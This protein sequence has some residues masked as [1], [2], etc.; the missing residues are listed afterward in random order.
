MTDAAEE[1]PAARPAIEVTS[2][3]L[4]NYALAHNRVPMVQHVTITNPTDVE[5][6]CALTVELSDSEG[7]LAVPWERSLTLRAGEQRTLDDINLRADPA[8]LLQVEEERPGTLRATVRHGSDPFAEAAKPVRVLAA[9][10]WLATGTSL[11]YEILPAFVMPNHPVVS[12]HLV[13][14]ADILGRQTGTS[15]LNGYQ[16]GPERVDAI[17]AAV[18][19]AVQCLHVRYAEPPASWGDGQKVRNPAQVLDERLG[20]CLDTVVGMA[21]ML[22]QAGIHPLLWVAEGHAFLGWWREEETSLAQIVAADTRRLLNLV[23]TGEIGLV[24]TTLVTDSDQPVG[25]AEARSA[26]ERRWTEED[27]GALLA[28]VDVN[29]ARRSG[30]TPLPARVRDA[31]GQVQITTYVPAEHS[32]PTLVVNGRAPETPHATEIAPSRVQNW[33]NALLDLSLRNRLINLP[34]DKASFNV[35]L[36]S[37]SLGTL[38]DLISADVSLHLFPADDVDDIHR[39]RGGLSAR[40]LPPEQLHESLVER[41]RVFTSLTQQTYQSRLR[42]LAHKARTIEEDT[43]ANNLYLTYGSLIWD[44]DGRE[45]RSPLILVPITLRAPARGYAYRLQMDPAGGSTPNFCL[46]EKLRQVHGL[47]IAALAE[48]EFDQSGIDLDGILQAVRIA[49]AQAGISARVE[50]SADV[51]ILQF[52]KFRL[53]RDLDQNWQ[54]FARNPLVK[55]LLET[56]TQPFTAAVADEPATDLDSLAANLPISAD[57]S[58]LR[59][60]ARATSGAT[61]VLEGPPGTGKSQTITNLLAHAMAEGRKV[62]FV[63]EKRAALDVVRRRLDAVGMGTFA[64]D[65]HDKSSK[66]LAVRAQIRKALDSTFAVDRHGLAAATEDMSAAARVLGRYAGR[67]HEENGAGLSLYSAHERLLAYGDGPKLAVPTALVGGDPDSVERVRSALRGLPDVADAIRPRPFH[68]WG[69]VDQALDDSTLNITRAAVERADHAVA[70]LPARAD[71]AP[72]VAAARNPKDLRT[73]AEVF[74]HRTIPLDALDATRQ[75]WW[76]DQARQTADEIRMFVTAAHPGLDVVTPNALDMPLPDILARARAAASS[77]FFGRKKRIATV[78]AELNLVLRPGAS[79]APKQL[80]ALLEALVQVQGA[81][82]HVASRVMSVNGVV[83]PPGWNPLTQGGSQIVEAQLSWLEWAGGALDA[84]AP[85][86]SFVGLVRAA[87]RSGMTVTAEEVGRLREAADASENLER[88]PGVGT[89]AL[90]RWAGGKGLVVAIASTAASRGSATEAARALK[91][92]STFVDQLEPL[93]NAGMHDARERLSRGGLD[94]DLAA[95]AFARGIATASIAERREATGLVDF[96]PATHT[97]SIERFLHSSAALRDLMRAELPNRVVTA[98]PFSPS[99]GLG[100]VGALQRELGRQRGGM[101]V[102]RLLATFGDLIIS[103]MP[104]VL[105]SPESVARFLPAASNLFDLVV[106]DEASQ[107]RVADAVGSMGRGRSVIV[108]GD[109]RQMPPTSFAESSTTADDDFEDEDIITVEDEESILSECVQA[110]VPRDWLS[111]HY[112]SQDETLIAFSNQHYY[113]SRLSSFPSPALGRTDPR[114]G[115]RG[116]NFVRVDGS[117]Q[118]SGRGKLLRTNQVEANA[119]VDDI[120]ARFAA[121]PDRNPSVGVVTFNVQQRALI[122]TMLR[123]LGDERIATALDDRTGEGVFVKNLENVQGDERDVILFSVAFSRNERGVLPLNFGPL[124]RGGG[125]RRLN[126]AVTRARRQVVVYCSFDPAELRSEETTS[127][128]IKHLRSYLDFAAASSAMAAGAPALAGTPSVDRHRD[129]IADALRECEFDVHTDVGMSDFRVDLVLSGPDGPA[130]AVLLDGPGWAQRGCVG[131]RDGLPTQVLTNLLHWPAVERVWLPEWLADPK[132]V[133]SRLSTAVLEAAERAKD[134]ATASPPTPT[135]EPEPSLRAAQPIAY[136]APTWKLAGEI[137]YVAAAPTGGTRAMLDGLPGAS[138]AA[139]VQHVTS[140]VIEHEGPISR[141]RLA[142]TVAAAFGLTRVSATRAEAIL[143]TIPRGTVTSE[144]G[145]FL[146]PSHISADSWKEFRRSDDYAA[147]PLED[148]SLR[149]ISNA[150]AALCAAAL[151]M[152]E[153][154]LLRE[155]LRVFGGRRIT[156]AI[157]TRLRDALVFGLS[158]GR[159]RRDGDIIR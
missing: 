144:D 72:L 47:S 102:R 136:D 116:V 35:L 66:P 87:L 85:G 106:F 134:V 53:W 38:E 8:A 146:W 42:A 50:V 100:Q 29:R 152:N 79:I 17:V 147:R 156:T 65:L 149:E 148:I 3:D 138:E 81:A 137:P 131:D 39:A 86:E 76:K 34:A 123:E 2:V 73:L 140:Q 124:N 21:A 44:V 40:D 143:T 126:V 91:A 153:E 25:F 6:E 129:D 154:E 113:E 49:V 151:G 159:L 19:E 105:V 127:V 89:G 31:A 135:A 43:G 63:A 90:E 22:E 62:L 145:A 104:C 30:I 57:A 52:A 60:V 13:T 157:G 78:A 88:S 155:T 36:P 15:G 41:R 94:A 83:V 24:E 64:L 46:L 56:P 98:R 48:P 32:A 61:F 130:V 27:S 45:L 1:A 28:V 122:E 26:A 4:V 125:E 84:A 108:V 77:G 139:A 74:A 10:H 11:G 121:S 117:F 119:V 111:W 37:S 55:H 7:S 9:N 16:S 112:R 93:R 115:G 14:V 103:T 107:I 12:R 70:S 142:R 92:W 110:R 59:A 5:L 69:F 95:E 54:V 99:S 20:T 71:L 18:F 96:D 67:L 158:T 128:G 82:R 109:S 58:Q 120:R 75:Q 33:K 141:E 51:A 150:M 118:R 23:A 114:P 132:A 80:V 101:G 68:P 133:V 97:R